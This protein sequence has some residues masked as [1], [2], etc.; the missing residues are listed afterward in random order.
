MANAYDEKLLERRPRHHRQ[1]Q[2]KER[3]FRKAKRKGN[4]KD[5]IA[6]IPIHAFI[7]DIPILIRRDF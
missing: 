7:Q 5:L 4:K 6:G 1:A 3:G 2:T